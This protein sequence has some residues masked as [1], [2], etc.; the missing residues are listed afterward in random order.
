MGLAILLPSTSPRERRAAVSPSIS[1]LATFQ[2]CDSCNGVLVSSE[3]LRLKSLKLVNPRVGINIRYT[4]H[5]TTSGE[6]V[7]RYLSLASSRPLN[8]LRG[9]PTY[10]YFIILNS[11]SYFLSLISYPEKIKI[12]DMV[13]TITG[14]ELVVG[15]LA[16][17]L[18]PQLVRWFA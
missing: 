5:V 7:M 16:T 15:A 9:S 10:D 3:N 2:D 17:S 8:Q 12:L 14:T 1:P 11:T 18:P 4:L 6:A 13:W